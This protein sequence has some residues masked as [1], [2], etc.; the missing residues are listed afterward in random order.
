MGADK[1]PV[2]SRLPRCPPSQFFVLECGRHPF[3]GHDLVLRTTS[4][5]GLSKLGRCTVR[6][7]RRPWETHDGRDQ[8]RSD[9][10]LPGATIACGLVVNCEEDNDQEKFRSFSQTAAGK[11]SAWR[12]SRKSAQSRLQRLR[13]TQGAEYQRF[14]VSDHSNKYRRQDIARF[15]LRLTGSSTEL[16]HWR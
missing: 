2:T 13:R 3:R 4:A 15:A 9:G 5:T 16:C 10:H 6:H 12:A 11:L 8:L 7:V 14:I 1:P